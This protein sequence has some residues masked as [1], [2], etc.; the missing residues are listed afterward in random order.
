MFYFKEFGVETII[1]VKKELESCYKV[2]SYL[3][4]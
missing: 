3:T 1:N 4:F 2:F